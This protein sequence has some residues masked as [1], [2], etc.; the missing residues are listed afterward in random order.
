MSY[1]D[2]FTFTLK[3][4]RSLN[5]IKSGDPM[6]NHFLLILFSWMAAFP[7]MAQSGQSIEDYLLRHQLQ[8]K[9]LPDGLHAIS[10][11]PGTGGLPKDGDYVLIEYK[12]MLL[13]STV[14]DASEPGNPFLFQVGNREVIKG[15]DSAVKTMKKGG[16][17]LFLIPAALGYK[18]YGIEGSVPPE[19]PLM[20]E[21]KLLD[22]MD[23]DQYDAYMRRLEEREKA[24]F[25]RQ[26]K[27][28]VEKDLELIE[29]YITEHQLPAKRTESGLSYVITKPGK[30]AMARKGNRLK[31]SY[32]GYFLNGNLFEAS[33]KP[34]EFVLGGAAV[35]QGW[36]EGF[37]FFNQ[38]S[39]GW[40]LIPSK[41]AY[42]PVAVG[43][44]PANAVLAFKV[45]VVEIR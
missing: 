44:I 37:Q 32:E 26:K 14:F 39:E 11:Y 25:E 36:E 9:A 16:N 42:G 38:G 24:A 45:K 20:Y 41:L 28:Q 5:K 29:A 15:L 23:F 1:R 3:N 13:D 4:M 40:L 30:G 22:I 31:I 33:E 35:I 8:A 7:A 27:E 43:K 17:S 2:N 18:Q 12:G 10:Q 34:F 19:S 21:V 6:K